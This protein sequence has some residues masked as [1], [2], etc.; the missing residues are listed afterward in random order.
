MESYC[1]QGRVFLEWRA[2]RHGWAQSPNHLDPRS[3]FSYI[4]KAHVHVKVKLES[5]RGGKI[6][7]ST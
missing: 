4:L 5:Q 7:I 2:A 6:K 3:N 1:L